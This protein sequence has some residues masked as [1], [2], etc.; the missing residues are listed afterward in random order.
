MEV[1]IPRRYIAQM[2]VEIARRVDEA[3][4][5][6]RAAI[7]QQQYFM[8]EALSGWGD[9]GNHREEAGLGAQFADAAVNVQGTQY[10]VGGQVSSGA[11]HGEA[12]QQWLPM[13]MEASPVPRMT[14]QGMPMLQAPR[15]PPFTVLAR[16]TTVLPSTI[17]ADQSAS[18]FSRLDAALQELQQLEQ[19]HGPVFWVYYLKD[20]RGLRSINLGEAFSMAQFERGESAALRT[21]LRHLFD[22]LY[23]CNGLVPHR[24]H[25]SLLVLAPK[26][27]KAAKPVFDRAYAAVMTKPPG[28]RIRAA[29]E[30]MII[31]Y[32]DPNMTRLLK[33]CLR[34]QDLQ[35]PFRSAQEMRNKRKENSR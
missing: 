22:F 30:N 29:F 21:V 15:Q 8:A 35:V 27:T 24:D 18:I 14:S 5:Q 10:V 34:V 19:M 33:Q 1:E 32:V 12:Q 23:A 28:T 17:T 11:S 13:R 16:P 4:T 25:F 20:E 7:P 31:E 6:R 9:V 2:E 26:F 3:M